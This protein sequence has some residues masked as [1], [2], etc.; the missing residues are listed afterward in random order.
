M[1]VKSFPKRRRA[2]LAVLAASGFALVG[3]GS[4]TMKHGSATVGIVTL[5]VRLT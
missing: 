5:S 1:G 3:C 4:A 2:V